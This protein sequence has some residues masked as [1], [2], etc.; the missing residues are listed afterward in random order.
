VEGRKGEEEKE[1][2]GM[3]RNGMESATARG[4]WEEVVPPFHMTCLRDDDAR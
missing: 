4:R 3:E 1:R 2:Q